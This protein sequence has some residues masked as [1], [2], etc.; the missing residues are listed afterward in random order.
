MNPEN[1]SSEERG[2]NK[3][4]SLFKRILDLF[5][6]AND[7]E[8]EKKKLLKQIEKNLKKQRVKFYNAKKRTVLPPLAKLFYEYYRILGPAQ[9]LVRTSEQSQSLKALIVEMS[10]TDEQISI[11]EN[12]SENA[13]RKRMEENPNTKQLLENVKDELKTFFSYFETEKIHEINALYN[14]L[15]IL[16]D[17]IHFDFYF[18]LK[19]FD[20]T[21]PENDFV[22][23]PHFEEIDAE[24][25]SDDLKDFLEILPAI[26]PTADWP[27]II[28]ML[29]GYRNIEIISDVNWKKLLQTTKQLQKSHVLEML[30]RLIDQDPFYKPKPRFHKEKV[31]ESYLNKLKGQIEMTVQRIIHEKRRSRI[32]ELSQMLFGSTAV[33]R[34]KNYSEKANLT[35]SKRLLGGYSYIAPLNFLKAFLLDFI[36]KDVRELVDLL[37][38]RGKWTTNKIS[39]QLSESY[40][41]LLKLSDEITEFDNSLDEEEALGKKI[42]AL[43]VKTSR[44]KQ[45]ITQLRLLLKEVNDT[46]KG[47]LF[48]ASENLIELA[49]ML[50]IALEDYKKEHPE[51]LLN[52]KEIKSHTDKD[53]K[54]FIAKVYNSIYYFLQ[55]IRLYK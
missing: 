25:V 36:K 20:S 43:L 6:G 28:G 33:I 42:K 55:L 30:V 39:Q 24:Y 27:K 22:Y 18:L 17:L 10:L 12:L 32:N 46:A 15:A 45:A 19:K 52:W 5:T 35:F 9:L 40:H 4:D 23:K 41:Q 54:N 11:R 2:K 14:N 31:V 1:P 26:D 47:F 34:L 3:K 16:L 48:R 49:R 51:L 44:D 13:L 50:K 53:I 38:I 21:L 29:N 7:P 37:L 8:R